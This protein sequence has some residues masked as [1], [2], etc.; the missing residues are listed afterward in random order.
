MTHPLTLL[1]RVLYIV[2]DI[3]E[4]LLALRFLFK[5]AAANP[6]NGL[7][8]AL[9]S[10]TDALMRPFAGIFPSLSLGQGS[11]LEWT[12]LLSIA[13]YALAVYMIVQVVSIAVVDVEVNERKTAH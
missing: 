11:V 13:L 12:T 3:I 10:A 5:L 2:L 4:G 1:Y 7:V 9:Y 8:R 6:A